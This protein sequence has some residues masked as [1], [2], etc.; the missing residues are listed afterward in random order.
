MDKPYIIGKFYKI[1]DAPN[2][3]SHA[4]KVGE[5]VIIR[6]AVKHATY[7]WSYSTVNENGI[8]GY[9]VYHCE[10]ESFPTTME[11]LTEELK[12]VKETGE[13]LEKKIEWMIKY[14]MEEFNEKKFKM[15]MLIESL[16]PRVS[17]ME[18]AE[19]LMK[20]FEDA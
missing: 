14:K 2:L 3:S 17:K 5:K 8:T 9:T 6:T 11:E 13:A 19:N 4:Y 12:S 7:K 20:I 1:A 18:Q 16:D 15:Y 10:L